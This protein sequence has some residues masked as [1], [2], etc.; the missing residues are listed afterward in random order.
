MP[1]TRRNIVTSPTTGTCATVDMHRSVSV[2]DCIRIAML[3]L[4]PAAVPMLRG[5]SVMLRA[6]ALAIVAVNG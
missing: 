3:D 6:S 5:K 4:D 1:G 2:T